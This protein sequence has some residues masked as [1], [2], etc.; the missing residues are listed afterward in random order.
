M[1]AKYSAGANL[2]WASGLLL[3]PLMTGIYTPEA[4]AFVEFPN[5]SIFFSAVVSA[6][7][8]NV[9][10]PNKGPSSVP[11]PCLSLRRFLTW[12]RDDREQTPASA[13]MR[14]WWGQGFCA[15]PVMGTSGHSG[16]VGRVLASHSPCALLLQ[17]PSPLGGS[18]GDGDTD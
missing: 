16:A 10:E 18:E 5:G 11:S 12:L 15:E 3:T 8:E 2:A 7:C 4:P 1:Q 6:A 13:P 14:E 9:K 17:V